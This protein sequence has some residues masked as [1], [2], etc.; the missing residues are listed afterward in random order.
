M[1]TYTMAAMFVNLLSMQKEAAQQ[2]EQL[3]K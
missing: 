1:G 3:L 2:F